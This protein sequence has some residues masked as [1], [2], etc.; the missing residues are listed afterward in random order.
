MLRAWH[1]LVQ[2]RRLK[3]S[4]CDAKLP[5]QKRGVHRDVGGAFGTTVDRR[6]AAGDDAG[7][8]QAAGAGHAAGH[9]DAAH[10]GRAAHVVDPGSGA[11]RRGCGEE[12]VGSGTD[13]PQDVLHID[14]GPELVLEELC[15]LAPPEAVHH[16]LKEE[17]PP[18]RL[19]WR[20]RPVDDAAA[21]DGAPRPPQRDL[22][23]RLELG[24]AVRVDGLA[25]IGLRPQRP[26]AIVHLIGRDVDERRLPPGP[27]PLLAE[28]VEQAGRD[29]DRPRR[30]GVL[31]ANARLADRGAVHDQRHLAKRG[32]GLRKALAGDQIDLESLGISVEMRRVSLTIRKTDLAGLG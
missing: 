14:G 17:R 27:T 10:P 31:L 23:L 3:R 1:S 2:E 21:E 4:C 11:L 6:S 26:P 24:G 18:D 25:G 20:R 9:V 12:A 7:R 13:R 16:E 15:P 22:A 8:V 29:V 32:E 30:L 28:E 19:C 5:L